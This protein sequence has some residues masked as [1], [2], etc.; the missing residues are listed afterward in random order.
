M[1]VTFAGSPDRVEARLVPEAGYELD[2]FLVSGL[3]RKPTPALLKALFRAG[4]APL[5]CRRILRSRRPDVVFGGGGFVAGP[6]VLAASTMRIPAALSEA[7]AHLGLANRLAMPYARRVFLAYPTTA[8]NRKK[9]RVV[10]RPIP[11]RSRPLP[12]SEGREIFELPADEPVLAVFGALAADV[13]NGRAGLR[14]RAE[15]ELVD[16]ARAERAAEHEHDR[17]VRRQSEP[18]A[19]LRARRGARAR[20][21]RPSD[22]DVLVAVPSVHRK[23]EE[24]ALRERRREPVRKPEVRVGFR[25]HCGDAAQACGKHHRSR[26]VAAAAEHDVWLTPREDPHARD[27]SRRRE[28][29]RTQ[30]RR[31]RPARKA[32][33]RERVEGVA[34]LRDEPRLDA[35][36]RPGERHR[37]SA[38]AQR[39][40]HGERRGEMPDRS[41]CRDQA[42]KLVAFRHDHGRC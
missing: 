10:G 11:A 40:R 37:H 20:R 29:E 4:R 13:Q 7:D 38:R 26:D 28:R 22:R 1:H 14:P 25:Q 35:I 41:P 12:Q 18:L 23:R 36:R 33:D 17:P 24:D 2:T 30:L 16:E 39:F 19:R 42:A 27:G 31:S 6:M 3:P 15:R 5:A 9:Y 34:L 21:H 8:R 32:R